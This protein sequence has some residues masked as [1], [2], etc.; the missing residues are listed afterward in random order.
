MTV[1]YTLLFQ[2]AENPRGQLFRLARE[3]NASELLSLVLIETVYIKYGGMAGK[4]AYY[5]VPNDYN[6]CVGRSEKN[7][8]TSMWSRLLLARYLNAAGLE[9]LPEDL[10]EEGNVIE[11]HQGVVLTG[12]VSEGG[13][14]FAAFLVTTAEAFP[15]LELVIHPV[16]L[17]SLEGN[18]VEDVQNLWSDL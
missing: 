13:T 18:G 4:T 15:G 14:V 2:K 17:R 9:P 8:K 6:K 12:H 16:S 7:M 5:G 1:R 3:N 10:L 11:V